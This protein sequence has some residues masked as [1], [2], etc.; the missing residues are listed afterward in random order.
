MA[1]APCPVFA[2]SFCRKGGKQYAGVSPLERLPRRRWRLPHS[3][4]R[5]F[6]G[7]EATAFALAIS[8]SFNALRASLPCLLSGSYISTVW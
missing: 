4:C 7:V 6:A 2:T 1:K 5:H 3:R 8:G